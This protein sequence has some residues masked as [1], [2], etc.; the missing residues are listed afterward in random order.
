[1]IAYIAAPYAA[2]SPSERARNVARACLLARAIFL[3]RGWSCIVPH[4]AIHAGAYGDDADPAQRMVGSEATLEQVRMVAEREGALV[5][6]SGEGGGLSAGQRAEIEE[7]SDG[8][9][10]RAEVHSWRNWRAIL[11]ID[12]LGLGPEWDALTRDA[13][14]R[15][16]EI[17]HLRGVLA[18]HGLRIGRIIRGYI[19]SFEVLDGPDWISWVQHERASARGAWRSLGSEET[20][21]LVP[22][23]HADTPEEAIAMARA[24][25]SP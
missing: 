12:D 6:I 8:K 9:W 18:K 19:S 5:A 10:R 3:R 7:Y 25:V 17:E 11:T 24:K 20:E 2:P 15:P 14:C 23:Y 13:P 22:V 16:E 1:M 4:P 21:F